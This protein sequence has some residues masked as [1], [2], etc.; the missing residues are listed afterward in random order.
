MELIV[1]KDFSETLGGRFKSDGDYSAEYSGETFYES[2]LEPLFLKAVNNND[3]LN[4]NLDGTYGYPSSFID[5][6]F[7]RLSRMYGEKK[8][9]KTL[10][11]ISND[12]PGLIKLI[13]DIIKNSSQLNN[14]A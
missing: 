1:S 10:K 3:T 2:L 5:E 7:G 4:I 6:S 12:Q 8:V 13:K 14:N 9:L 11:F